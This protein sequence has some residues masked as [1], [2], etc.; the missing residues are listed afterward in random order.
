MTGVSK[1]T[2]SKLLLDL[3]AACTAY[4]SKTLVNL[5]SKRVQCDEIWSCVGAKDKNLSAEK[6]SR[7]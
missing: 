7:D 6:R 4:Q 2:I 5:P 3:G 1:N